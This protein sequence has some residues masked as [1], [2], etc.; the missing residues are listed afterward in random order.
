MM[1]QT[2][3]YLL[4]ILEESPEKFLAGG[5]FLSPLHNC[6]ETV[7]VESI[8]DL[9]DKLKDFCHYYL[10]TEIFVTPCTEH[11]AFG[12]MGIKQNSRLLVLILF[13]PSPIT[14]E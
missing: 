7:L 5:C 8:C 13:N 3:Q 1:G 12:D 10:F 11:C 9:I 14:V 4:E 2:I 6:S